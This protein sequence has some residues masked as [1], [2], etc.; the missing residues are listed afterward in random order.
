MNTVLLHHGRK[1]TVRADAKRNVRK[2]ISTTTKWYVR[3]NILTATNCGIMGI[4][5]IYASFRL[6]IARRRA[7][8]SVV[9]I[10]VGPFKMTECPI[11]KKPPDEKGRF[12]S[13]SRI[14]FLIFPFLNARVGAQ[15][16]K[17]SG[18]YITYAANHFWPSIKMFR[19][20]IGILCF[21]LSG[22]WLCFILRCL[23]SFLGRLFKRSSVVSRL[24]LNRKPARSEKISNAELIVSR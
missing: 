3:K 14:G 11:P 1:K 16:S 19:A 12:P 23:I 18:L 10:T 5:E 24:P 9:N 2:T 4:K 13:D 15:L 17:C 8:G 6:Q 22:P 7:G 21:V 20:A